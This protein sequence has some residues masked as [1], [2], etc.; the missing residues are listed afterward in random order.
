MKEAAL[1]IFTNVVEVSPT[2]I[3]EFILQES[4]QHDEVRFAAVIVNLLFITKCQAML[5]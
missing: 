3:R 2:M 1:E 5:R 4:C